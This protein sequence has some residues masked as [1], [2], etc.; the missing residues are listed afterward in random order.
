MSEAGCR[1][2]R[3]VLATILFFL[4]T[5]PARADDTEQRD[6]SVFV[7]GKEAGTSRMLLVQKNDGTSY[8][9]ATL[10]V[11]FRQVIIDFTLKVETQ[12]WWKQGRL[13]AMKTIAHE[14]NKRTEVVASLNN[15]QLRVRVNNRESV[16]NPEVWTNSFWKLADS[17]F[18][19]TKIPILEVDTGKE[20]TGELKY[21]GA[22]KLKVG[23]DFVDCYHFVVSTNTG[24]VEVWYDRYHRLVRQESTE[25]G[26]KIIV[27]LNGVRR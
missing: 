22:K 2:G 25:S 24:P 3:C 21:S 27:Q 7:D 9:S 8:M 15:N 5:P 10:D 14:N 12:E 20:F 26:H 4:T 11:K 13:I 17:R 18:H 23:N 6:F 19:N 1:M 16:V